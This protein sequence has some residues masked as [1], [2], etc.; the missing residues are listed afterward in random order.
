MLRHV[1]TCCNI[2]ASIFLLP[3][4]WEHGNLLYTGNI[5]LVTYMGVVGANIDA[6]VSVDV[7]IGF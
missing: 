6:G 5:V 4:S 2:F 1:L 7:V 3:C